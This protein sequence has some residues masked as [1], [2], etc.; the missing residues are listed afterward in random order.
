[1]RIL[2]C[3]HVPLLRRLG[4][5]KVFLEIHE[6]YLSIGVESHVCGPAEICPEAGDWPSIETYVRGLRSYLQR[7]AGEFDVVEYEHSRLPFPRAEFAPRPL[8]VARSVLLAHYLESIPLPRMPGIRGLVGSLINGPRRRR[9]ERQAVAM[10]DSTLRGADLINVC[11]DYDFQE[12]CRRGYAANRIL[13]FP[14][15]LFAQAAGVRPAG[16]IARG[17]PADCLC[18]HL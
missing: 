11:N 7:R 14:F 17:K 2:L 10:A 6:A 13:T 5:A 3:S 15:G 18:G 4:A 9:G 1:M 8:L 12:L 16:A